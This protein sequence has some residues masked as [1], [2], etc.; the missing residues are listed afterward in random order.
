MEPLNPFSEPIHWTESRKRVFSSLVSA[1]RVVSWH[2][3]ERTFH[4]IP[5]NNLIGW[6]M[7]RYRLQLPSNQNQP[8]VPSLEA[9]WAE[10]KSSAQW[11][12]QACEDPNRAHYIHIQVSYFLLN[13]FLYILLF[14]LSKKSIYFYCKD[15]SVSLLFMAV[16]IAL[17]TAESSVYFREQFE[18][19]GKFKSFVFYAF[20]ILFM[21]S[22]AFE[23]VMESPLDFYVMESPICHFNGLAT[24]VC[25]IHLLLLII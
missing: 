12:L 7:W 22:L 1:K 5:Q 17:I 6:P 24:M 19:G 9:R 15:D 11:F 8:S 20:W 25:C 3:P 23:H 21:L 10:R 16:S 14:C 2:W 4:S 18:D 13:R